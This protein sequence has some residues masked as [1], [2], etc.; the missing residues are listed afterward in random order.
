VLDEIRD[1]LERVLDV[2]HIAVSNLV[3]NKDLLNTLIRGTAKPEMQFIVRS[4]LIFGF[5]IGLVQASVWAATHS[6]WVMPVFGLFTGWFTDWLA[7]KMIFEPKEPKRYLGIAPWHG[8]FLKRRDEF[9]ADYARAMA[10]EIFTPAVVMESLL[11]GPTADRLFA[12]VQREVQRAIDEEMGIARPVVSLAMGG[13]RYAALKRKIAEQAISRI[14]ET[15]PLVQAYADEVLEIEKLIASK[16]QELTTAEYEG[17][18]RPAFKEDEWIVIAV[19]ALLGFLV[20]E[21]QVTL[22]THFTHF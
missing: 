16:M 15:A 4:G 22:V 6:V 3:R 5:A 18:L 12:V 1:D 20:G 9:S 2:R 21:L 17:L 11:T 13:Q 19:G 7:L 14:H 10:S 8:L